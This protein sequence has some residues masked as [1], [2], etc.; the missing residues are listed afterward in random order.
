ML[1]KTILLLLILFTNFDCVAQEQKVLTF[2][3][4]KT[5]QHALNSNFLKL[6]QDIF[7]PDVFIETGTFMGCT[8]DTAAQIFKEVYSIELDNWLYQEATRNFQNRSNIHLYQGDSKS[9]L[10]KILPNLKNKKILI[11][12]DAHWSGA[13]TA[14]GDET[15]PILGELQNIKNNNITNIV[16][17]IDDIRYFQPKSVVERFKQKSNDQ[18]SLGFPS[19]TKLKKVITEIN[20]NFKTVL[21]GDMFIAFENND[22]IIIPEIL[23][24][25]DISRNTKLDNETEELLN[26]EKVISNAH[27]Y[28]VD[29]LRGLVEIRGP[30]LF[31]THY[32]YWYSLYLL[33]KNQLQEAS[34]RLNQIIELGFVNNRILNLLNQTKINQ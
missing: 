20:P 4:P 25:F 24:A 33:N 29:A 3:H 9:V 16:I 17:V 7:N 27:G 1:K 32:N 23:K 28:E 31:C 22:N 12:L 13:G 10:N 8:T 30:E 18:T 6:L 26:A 5:Y 34:D 11:Y 2:L 15:T 19:M 14:C 21:Y